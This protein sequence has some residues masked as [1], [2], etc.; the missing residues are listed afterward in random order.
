M[1]RPIKLSSVSVCVVVTLRILLFSLIIHLVDSDMEF[2][3]HQRITERA[4]TCPSVTQSVALPILNSYYMDVTSMITGMVAM[5][6][7]I[8]TP[9]TEA[10]NNHIMTQPSFTSTS[11]ST[12]TM[13]NLLADIF[14][15]TL[16]ID[17][18]YFAYEDTF[19]STNITLKRVNRTLVRQQQHLPICSSVD[20]PHLPFHDMP[21]SKRIFK[22]TAKP[23]FKWKLYCDQHNSE[24][25]VSAKL[26]MHFNEGNLSKGVMDKQSS[27]KT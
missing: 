10:T 7:Y 5:V 21:L 18:V 6:P 19:Y 22:A 3:N 25:V 16:D 11:S 4:T 2:H 23:Q 13:V 9:D 1:D 14:N 24:I 27:A 12:Q 8:F 15:P 26:L 20:S 17:D